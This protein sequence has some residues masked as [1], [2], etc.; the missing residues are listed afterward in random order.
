MSRARKNP[1][2]SGLVDARH[3]ELLAEAGDR[4]RRRRCARRRRARARRPC[5]SCRSCTPGTA[6]STR[7][8]MRPMSFGPPAGQ[9]EGSGGRDA[10]LPDLARGSAGVACRGGTRCCRWGSGSRSLHRGRGVGRVDAAPWPRRTSAG[11][12][13]ACRPR[14][15]SGRRVDVGAAGRHRGRRRCRRAGRRRGRRVDGDR[16]GASRRRDVGGAARGEQRRHGED[17]AGRRRAT[18]GIPARR[19]RNGDMAQESGTERRPGS[20]PSRD[21]V[22]YPWGVFR[23]LLTPRWVGMLAALAVVV[24][25]CVLLGLWQ[26]GV[27]RDSGRQDAVAAASTPRPRAPLQQVTAP[28]SDFQAE[29]LQPCRHRD[30]DVCRW[31]QPARRRPSAGRPGR[32]RGS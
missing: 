23:R 14:G 8:S 31:A 1:C 27:A 28:H 16:D 10:P 24:A 32:A 26:L 22:T 20:G 15:P 6:P 19:R 7:S 29:L 4:A 18:P 30:G 5:G 12:R 25:A 3:A 9:I 11:R 17:G 21:R 13:A 2:R